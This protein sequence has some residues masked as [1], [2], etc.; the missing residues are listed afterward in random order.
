[1][2]SCHSVGM[3]G[4]GGEVQVIISCLLFKTYINI[5]VLIHIYSRC[6]SFRDGEWETPGSALL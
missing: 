1:M 4:E 3:R 6:Y 2:G 5:Y